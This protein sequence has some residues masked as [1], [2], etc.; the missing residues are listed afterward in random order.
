MADSDESDEIVFPNRDG[1][2]GDNTAAQRGP[3]RFR[4]SR[5]TRAPCN[6]EPLQNSVK[7][8]GSHTTNDR[9]VPRG[10]APLNLN[11]QRDAPNTNDRRVS[12]KENRPIDP[13]EDEVNE[14]AR[15]RN[16]I[17]ANAHRRANDDPTASPELLTMCRDGPGTDRYSKVYHEMANFGV[18][19]GDDI[20]DSS[21]LPGYSQILST[22]TPE[23]AEPEQLISDLTSRLKLYQELYKKSPTAYPIHTEN[24][25]VFLSP[26]PT[27]KHKNALAR[28]RESRRELTPQPTRLFKGKQVVKILETSWDDPVILDWEYCPRCIPDENAYRVRFQGWLEDTINRE[29]AVDIFHQ[30]FFNGTAHA[31]G[32]T[33]MFLLDMRSYETILDPNDKASWDYAHETAA[34]YCYNIVLHNRKADEAEEHRKQLDREIRLEARRLQ[35]LRSPGSPVANIYLRPVDFKDV[36]EL[37]AIYN[38]YA[39]NSF[40]S[41]NTEDLDNDEVRQRI[42]ESRTTKLPFIVAIDRRSASTNAEK[43]LGYALA[44]DFD[45]HHLASRFTAE[46]EVYVKEGHTG[47]GIGRCLLDKLL[48]VCDPTY[49]PRSGYLFEAVPEDRS[50]YYP[51]G[52]RRL[53]RLVFSLCY[54]D[55]QEI[56]NHKRVKE[57]LKDYAG[58]EEQGLL[59]GVRVK[60]NYL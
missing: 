56:S 8:H 3:G 6:V 47:L 38:W 26:T 33:S 25:K 20:P 49:S 13:V 17:V 9:R 60:N 32:Q 46:L 10:P 14:L 24:E 55:R 57:W 28:L 37:R 50:G 48:E 44:R 4:G 40:D 12:Q 41:P 19:P 29:C 1:R 7:Q 22:E 16:E 15:L 30:A 31:D 5:R 36:P 54:V 42:E 23:D 59:R 27:A 53:A 21:Y 45:R 43:I 51:G 34:G 52:R 2:R 35:P 18:V 11:L 58:F 39:R